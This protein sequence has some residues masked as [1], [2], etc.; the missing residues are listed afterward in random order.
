VVVPGEN[1]IA[2]ARQHG[3]NIAAPL[4]RLV[5]DHAGQPQR[6]HHRIG[7]PREAEMNNVERCRCV[8][9]VACLDS[10]NVSQTVQ[11]LIKRLRLPPVRTLPGHLL[12]AFLPRYPPAA[13][14]PARPANRLAA[15][16]HSKHPTRV[17]HDDVQ[18]LLGH[19]DAFACCVT[20]AASLR[21]ASERQGRDGRASDV[22][23]LIRH[24]LD[25]ASHYT[26]RNP[27]RA[28]SALAAPVPSTAGALDLATPSA[29]FTAMR[30]CSALCSRIL[31]WLERDIPQTHS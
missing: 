12:P 15:P 2:H 10:L 5:H 24:P 29:T 17:I 30:R 6:R 18:N 4:S 9:V 23:F 21:T 8:L 16:C 14:I 22:R 28:V 13:M 19:D 27:L 3:A 26:T 31:I 20:M 1:S 7:P 11:N 25:P